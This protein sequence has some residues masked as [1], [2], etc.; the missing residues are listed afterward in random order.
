MMVRFK[1]LLLAAVAAVT[2]GSI[3]LPASAQEQLPSYA[4]GPADQTV[5]GV[6]SGFD[7]KYV[8]FVRDDRGF[9]DRIQL[10]DGTIINPTG[11]RLQQG[12]R[13]SVMGIPSGNSFLANQIDTPYHYVPVA[14]P[15]P[16][17]WAPYPYVRARVWF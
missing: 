15:Y 17:G 1:N 16:Y 11:L 7:G 12:M 8:L 14:Y 5:R 3:A 9:T 10:R 6:V 13:V 2:L 4:T